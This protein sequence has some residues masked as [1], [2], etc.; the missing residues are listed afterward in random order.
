M[1]SFLVYLSPPSVSSCSPC[2]LVWLFF[3]VFFSPITFSSLLHFILITRHEMALDTYYTPVASKSTIDARAA[4]KLWDINP[5]QVLPKILRSVETS[6][7]LQLTELQ[8]AR[9][10]THAICEELTRVKGTAA[11]IKRTDKAAL[12]A[13]KHQQSYLSTLLKNVSIPSSLSLI[14]FS[15]PH[16]ASIVGHLG[17]KLVLRQMS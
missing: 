12:V 1:L 14:L 15:L 2:S 3:W 11:Q 9:H 6:S 7:R 5:D 8:L 10:A 4:F 13:S 16:S 17:C